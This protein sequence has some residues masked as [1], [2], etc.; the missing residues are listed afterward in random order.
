MHDVLAHRISLLSV[1]AGALAYRTAQAESGQGRALSGA[2]VTGAVRVIRDSAHQALA[3]LGEVLSVL[4]ADQPDGDGRGAPQPMLADL[5]RLVEEARSAG[6]RVTLELDPALTNG[7]QPRPQDQRTVYR[8]VQEGLTNAR[9]HAPDARVVV[10]VAGEPGTGL[11]VA[12]TNPLPVGVAAVEIP[13]AGAGLTGLAER[14]GLDGGTLDHGP[15][16][17][18]FRLAARLPWQA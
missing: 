12:V 10:R 2:E 6:Q 8:V 15:V 4:R 9:K 3:E 13:G 1:H 7:R 16:D 18:A 14:V 11:A 5:P 17:G